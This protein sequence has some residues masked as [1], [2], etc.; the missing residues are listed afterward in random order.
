MTQMKKTDE[1]FNTN[2]FQEKKCKNFPVLYLESENQAGNSNASMPIAQSS[3]HEGLTVQ[4]SAAPPLVDRQLRSILTIDCILCKSSNSVH[5]RNPPSSVNLDDAVRLRWHV[6]RFFAYGIIS[7][8]GGNCSHPFLFSVLYTIEKPHMPAG[9]V[10]PW[11][12]H[13]ERGLSYRFSHDWL[14]NSSVFSSTIWAAVVLVKNCWV[15][16]KIANK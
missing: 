3:R 9:N 10:P 8:L 2:V 11:R 12:R 13:V 15:R 7:K 4:S 6:H 1:V 14:P 5:L 16:R